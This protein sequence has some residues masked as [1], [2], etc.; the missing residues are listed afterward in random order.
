MNGTVGSLA[1]ERLPFVIV[2]GGPCGLAAAWQLC[3]LGIK[4]LVLEGEAVFGG[5]CATHERDGWRFDLGGHRFVSSDA[6]LSRWLET[7]LGSDL[8]VGE[9]RSVVLYEGRQFRY[10]LDAADLLRSLGPM[11]NACAFLSWLGS[12]ARAQLVPRPDRSFED[13]VTARFGQY[14]YDRFFGP[15]TQK[16]WGIHPSLISADWARE[17]ISLLDLRDVILRLAGA[18]TSPVRTYAR[19]YLYPRLGMGQLYRAIAEDVRAR[20]G[21][22]R[23]GVRVVGVESSGDRA[24]AVIVEG[25]GTAERIPVGALLS[26]MPLPD[27]ARMLRP[28]APADIAEAAKRLRFRA[29]SFVNL[30][31]ARSDFSSNTWMY[32]ASARHTMSRIQEPKRRSRWMAPEGRTSL[33]L[34][35]PCD[36]ED[37]TW[38][39]SASEL[40][41]RALVELE[42]LGY[43][44][45]DVISSFVVRVAHGYPVY[46]LAYERDRQTLLA[47]V[48]RFANVR[49]AGRQGLFRYVFMDAAMQMGMRTAVQMV[50]GAAEHTSS[51]G[52]YR[53]GAA[54]QADALDAVIDAIGRSQEVVEGGALTA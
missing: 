51:A 31:L 2:G 52:R 20:G 50:T 9:R 37:T 32:V 45:R 1:A 47:E 29:L 33:M 30:M 36:V 5:L 7:L 54:P 49:T 48:R 39:A 12:R 6:V 13:W 38:N 14:L 53:G 35:V 10:P 28:D 21:E 19:R 8:L 40:R 3:R 26:T 44:I 15:Y 27:L 46:H 43:P 24:T 41:D 22:V 4:P 34:E 42:Q 17:R 25:G 18:R 23:S 16:L 11:E